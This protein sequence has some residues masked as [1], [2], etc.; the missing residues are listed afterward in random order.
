[1]KS[2]P[3]LPK[4]FLF[5]KILIAL[6]ARVVREQWNTNIAINLQIS[7]LELADMETASTTDGKL[8]VAF[9][10]HTPLG[11]YDMRAQL[12][13]ASGNKLLGTDGVLVSNKPSG[14]A[15]YVFNVCLDA[16]NN[17]VIGCQDQR[18]GTDQCVLYKISQTG[19]HLWGTD[20]LVLGPGLAPNVALL[21]NGEIVTAWNDAATNTLLLQKVTT[22]GTFAWATPVT[23]MVGSAKTTM[24]QIVS[25]SNGRFT[26]V[27][28]KRGTGIYTTLYAQQFYNTGIAQYAPLQIC[29]ETT[30]AIRYYSVMHE[31]D[32]TYV[33]YFSASG[34]RFNSWLQRINPNGTIPWGM[35]GSH[36]NTS[37]SA[38][39]NY[40]MTTNIRQSPGSPYV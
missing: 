1:M 17:L 22:G 15:T 23:V 2:N 21:T 29:S 38:S 30:H 14:T 6:N 5:L 12:F 25:N 10:Q 28:Q 39:D 3:V 37:T 24:G 36:F 35:N 18:S 16:A 19:A 33:G 27:Y 4:F 40:P 31:G 13:D 26:M 32:T 7:G 34:S 8:W 9:Y 20:G 11:N